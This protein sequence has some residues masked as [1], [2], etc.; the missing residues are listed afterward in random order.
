MVRR[1]H[2]TSNSRWYNDEKDTDN[3]VHHYCYYFVL[4]LLL[5]LLV[6]VVAVVVAVAVL[7]A[8]N[9]GILVFLNKGNIGLI[10]IFFLFCFHTSR[11]TVLKNK[12]YLNILKKQLLAGDW[13][14]TDALKY[15]NKAVIITLNYL[16]K[17]QQIINEHA[18]KCSLMVIIHSLVF[19]VAVKKDELAMF[20]KRITKKIQSY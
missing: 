18:N 13:G 14:N 15:E 17:G 5:L 12:I 16:L 9:Y 8:P 10:Y 4:L 3:D 1:V 2:F 7:V 11:V 19:G 6:V 20:S